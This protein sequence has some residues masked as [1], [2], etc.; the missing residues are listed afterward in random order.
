MNS[1]VESPKPNLA[2]RRKLVRGVFAAPAIM[3]VCSGSAFANTSNLRCL[4]HDT[5]VALTNATPKVWG[6]LDT[7]T[8]V[9][10]FEAADG[11]YYVSGTHV[12]SIFQ[13]SNGHF[14]GL[15]NWL[16]IDPVTGAI[17]GTGPIAL[18]DYRT[19][20]NVEPPNYPRLDRANP[21]YVIVRFDQTGS[22][23]G[24]GTAGTGYNV[25]A[26]CWNSFK[27]VV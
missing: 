3:T 7:W 20:Y 22:V 10:L 11:K 18:N 13:Q 2:A 27:D 23:T 25:G 16:W 6:G 4:K 21:K 17:G 8:R 15:G 9:Q 26:S 14:P 1:P 19:P 24:V 12:Q 5:T